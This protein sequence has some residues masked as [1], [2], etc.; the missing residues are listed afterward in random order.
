MPGVLA[1]IQYPLLTSCTMNERTIVRSL[2]TNE[3][4]LVAMND[5]LLAWKPTGGRPTRTMLDGLP[6]VLLAVRGPMGGVDT[7]A[8]G[9]ADGHVLV[10]T[11][12]RLE[13]VTKFTLDAGSLRALTLVE[14]GTMT[15]LAG[16]QFGHVFFLDDA[17]QQRT[18]QL[19]S[20]EG[21]VSSLHL[22]NDTVHVR[23]GWIHHVR[24]WDGS[25][26]RTDNTADRFRTTRFK[27]LDRSY[28]LPH[29]V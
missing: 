28:V 19:F 7:V 24:S 15:F 14:E 5:G 16:T 11:L 13:T 17:A 27:R 26:Q 18:Q 20:I 8:V 29:A 21:P 10:M 3:G 23:S 12:P 4:V 1:N 22:E 9:T 2:T 25:T 6:T